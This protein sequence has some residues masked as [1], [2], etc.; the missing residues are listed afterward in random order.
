LKLTNEWGICWHPIQERIIDS[1]NY[2]LESK[3]K[4][5]DK[6]LNTL[7]Q[8]QKHE[9]ITEHPITFHLR[10]VNKTSISFTHEELSLLNESLNYNM[11][12]K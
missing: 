1:V 5:L 10:T 9:D 8:K 2:E 3:Y 6:E 11:N 7:A 4:T 12:F